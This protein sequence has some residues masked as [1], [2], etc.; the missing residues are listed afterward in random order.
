M[1]CSNKNNAPVIKFSA[2]SNS[3][4]IKNIDE[5]S[6]FQVKNAYRTNSDSVNFISVLLT[7]NETDS[8]QTEKEVSGKI[9]LI[10]D[11]VLF[12]P[13]TPFLKGKTYL[14]ESYV[15]VKFADGGKL[16]KGTIKHSL[17]PQQQILKR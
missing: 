12:I 16:F 4:V 13:E 11:S 17:Q 6:L 14:V 8:L 7:P 5:A 10:G 15:G 1:S 3:I 9:N 2:D